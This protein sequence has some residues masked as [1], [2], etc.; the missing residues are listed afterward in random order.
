MLG[1]LI[2]QMRNRRWTAC[3]DEA[4]QSVGRR[5]AHTLGCRQ[6]G[7]SRADLARN[8]RLGY[9]I[10]QMH[11]RRWTACSK[12]TENHEKGPLHMHVMGRER[13]QFMWPAEHGPAW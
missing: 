8:G 2:R 10:S 6:H 5:S 4:G 9:L 3:A 7:R 1:Y 12:T 13:A 11:N